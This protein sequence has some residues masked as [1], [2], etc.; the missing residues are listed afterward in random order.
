MAER[1]DGLAQGLHGSILYRR[2][3]G[4]DMQLTGVKAKLCRKVGSVEVGPS[5]Q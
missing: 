1:R 2:L 5:R 4:L 3:G